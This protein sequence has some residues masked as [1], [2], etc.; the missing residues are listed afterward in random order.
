MPEPLPKSIVSKLA[1][2]GVDVSA[3]RIHVGQSKSE[4]VGALAYVKGSDIHFAPG[5][6]N[7]NSKAGQQLLGHELTHLVATKMGKQGT[8]TASDA[9]QMANKA[10]TGSLNQLNPCEKVSRETG[11]PVFQVK[12]IRAACGIE[13]E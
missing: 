6:Y 2:V 13:N 3:V 8:G 5:Q 9:E 7:P 11:L 4:A 10:A 12:A 1:A